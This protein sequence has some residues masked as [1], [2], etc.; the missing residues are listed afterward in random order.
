MPWLKR[1]FFMLLLV[2]IPCSAV[3]Q[4]L[5]IEYGTTSEL[6]GVTK[7]FVD[8]GKDIRQREQII[9]EL[10][11]S[12]PSLIV[13]SRPEDAEVHLQFIIRDRAQS[14]SVIYPY[15]YPVSRGSHVNIGVLVPDGGMAASEGVGVVLRQVGPNRARVLMSFRDAKGNPFERKPTTNF[16][17]N[18]V[19]AYKKANN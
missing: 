6:R 13:V 17:R 11:K 19:R 18:F 3:A 12:L 16:A 9:K 10:R 1:S 2:L 5:T 7:V 8:T 4:D 15:P 14:G